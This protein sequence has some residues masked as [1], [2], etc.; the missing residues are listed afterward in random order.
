LKYYTGIGS[1][2]TPQNVLDLMEWVAQRLYGMGYT[3]RSGRAPGADIAFERG[4]SEADTDWNKIQERSEIYLPWAKFGEDIATWIKPKREYAQK[5]AYELGKKY[6]P[7][8]KFLTYG[9]MRLHARNIH[10]IL[11][12]DVTKPEPS[13]FVICWT[14]GGKAGG[15]TGQA[16]RVANDFIIPIFD[17][18]NEDDMNILIDQLLEKNERIVI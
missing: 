11:G 4:L 17:L 5:E 10:Q 8:W 1:R 15:G 7:G 12:Y 13:E 6:H 9:A 3:L 18:A 2:E 16:I 14:E